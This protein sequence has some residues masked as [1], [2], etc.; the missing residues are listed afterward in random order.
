MSQTMPLK[1]PLVCDLNPVSMELWIDDAP[2]LVT[3][4]SYFDDL[5]Y[6]G[7]DLIAVMVDNHAREW[8]PMWSYKRMEK[9]GELCWDTGIELALTC[10]PWPDKSVIR[11]LTKGMTEM[12]KAAGPAAVEWE[13]D[14][15]ANWLERAVRGFRAQDGRSA[16]DLAGDY[17]IDAKE[18]AI[19]RIDEERNQ[20]LRSSMTTFTAHTENGRAADIAPYYD[21]LMPQ[22]YAVRHR[23]YRGK[24]RQ[25][26][27]EHTY[28]P[29]RMVEHTLDRTKLIVDSVY[30]ERK[31]H[32]ELGCGH[33]LYDQRW[34]MGPESAMMLNLDIAVGEYGCKRNRC[35]S[36]KW[37]IGKM[38]HRSPYAGD[39]LRAV[40]EARG[41][42]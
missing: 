18:E 14:M 26:P 36:S 5:L 27:Q 9:L 4:H 34:P 37:A 6:H 2:S 30:E 11:A 21:L 22:A 16:I 38:A 33:A 8:K 12:Y 3:T 35:W 17:W 32:I 23:R 29:G 10:W 15:E 13:D 7:V 24:N 28:G 31:H 42:A 39:F 41:R 40:A 19:A 20:A 1:R 25:V